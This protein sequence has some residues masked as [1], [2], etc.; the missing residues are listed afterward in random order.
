MCNGC[1]FTAVPRRLVLCLAIFLELT[2]SL[3]EPL[4]GLRE[5]L[6]RSAFSFKL[7]SS[8]CTLP[9]VLLRE[10]VL[11]SGS[12]EVALVSGSV[13]VALVSG[14]VEVAVV[15]GSVELLSCTESKS[16]CCGTSCRV[17]ECHP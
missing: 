16:G 7:L 2:G 15:S 11:V 3:E 17:E 10:V 13:E 9:T 5:A 4:F 6:G 14:S 8:L 1:F 12:V